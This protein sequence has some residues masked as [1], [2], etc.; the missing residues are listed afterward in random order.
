MSIAPLSIRASLDQYTSQA[1]DLV[2]AY[3]SGD[4]EAMYCIRQLH[5][6]LRG[7][8]HTN[9]R[10]EVTDEEIRQAGFT[11]ADAQCVVAR[12]Y[13]FENWPT[14]AGFVEAVTQEGSR[15]W[16]FESAVEAIITGDVTTLKHLLGDNPEL[17]RARSTRGHHATLLHYVGANGVEGSRQKTPKNAV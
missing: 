16:Q 5:P 1:T 11:I 13:E 10:N 3:R 7:R 8:A 12:W 14:L 4:P 15:I 6:R 17:I 9:D 2:K